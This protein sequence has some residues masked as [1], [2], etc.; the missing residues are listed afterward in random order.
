MG[1]KVVALPGHTIPVAAGTPHE[2]IVAALEEALAQAKA[3]R[4]IGFGLAKALDDGTPNGAWDQKWNY[5]PSGVWALS[6]AI[7]GLKADFDGWLYKK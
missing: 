7:N 1:D 5:H 4:L 6:V 2:G 3:G